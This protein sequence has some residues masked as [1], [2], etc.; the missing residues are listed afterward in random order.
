MCQHLLHSRAVGR[1]KNLGV[2]EVIQGFLKEKFLHLFLAKSGG[3]IDPTPPRL[4]KI[5]NENWRA[6]V[7]PVLTPHL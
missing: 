2:Q 3:A 7:K 5:S 1:F 4:S 6:K